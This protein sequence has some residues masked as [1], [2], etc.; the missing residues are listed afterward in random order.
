M[1]IFKGKQEYVPIRKPVREEPPEHQ[2]RVSVRQVADD[3]FYWNV[4]YWRQRYWSYH[5]VGEGYLGYADTQEK[6]IEAGTR[7]YCELMK[8]EQ[9]NKEVINVYPECDC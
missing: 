6:A 7:L 3:S 8:K 4:Q 2:Y 9:W 5:D 1:K